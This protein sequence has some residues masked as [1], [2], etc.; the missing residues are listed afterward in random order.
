MLNQAVKSKKSENKKA[1]LLWA[2]REAKDT[3]VDYYDTQRAQF[4]LNLWVIH[5]KSP[6]A[7]LAKA[8]ECLEQ[9]ESAPSVTSEW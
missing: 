8:L 6:T 2:M 1:K 9:G 4:T 5:L 7:A 3:G